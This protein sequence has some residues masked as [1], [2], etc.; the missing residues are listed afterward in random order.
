[1][2]KIDSEY[3]SS[4]DATKIS[5]DKVTDG[6]LIIK[7]N[8]YF[9]AFILI[10]FQL[11]F[12][13][14]EYSLLGFFSTWASRIIPFLDILFSTN[15]YPLRVGVSSW[16]WNKPSFLLAA[17]AAAAA[18]KLLQSC[19]T[20]CNPIDSSPPGSPI[21]GI[22]QARTL[23]WVAIS[24]SSAW[25]WKMKVKLLSRVWLFATPWTA[26]YQVPPPMGFSRQ[27]YWSGL[28]LPSPIFSSYSMTN[29]S[30]VSFP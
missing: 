22:I 6:L 8:S 14:V 3:I 13:S 5:L 28:P 21:P 17:A 7:S 11:L 25:K 26:A 19:L 27:E 24:F 23:E 12:C 15:H 18:A 30:E 9:F 16:F 10:D 4:H 20:L 1:M 2:P 29:P